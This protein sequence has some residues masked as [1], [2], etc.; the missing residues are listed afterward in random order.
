MAEK[1]TIEVIL[2]SLSAMLEI[3][4]LK[5]IKNPVLQLFINSNPIKARQLPKVY[6]NANFVGL[7][8]MTPIKAP[9]ESN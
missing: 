8:V 2:L 4:F 9:N 3:C 1:N 7:P 5:P 6:V